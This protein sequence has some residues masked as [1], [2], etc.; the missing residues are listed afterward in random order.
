MREARNYYQWLGDQLTTQENYLKKLEKSPNPDLYCLET[1]KQRVIDLRDRQ[2]QV[3]LDQQN[4]ITTRN[5]QII[6][7]VSM[8]VSIMAAVVAWHNG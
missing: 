4:R 8:L 2:Y 3:K 1:I 7:L 5:A 6:A